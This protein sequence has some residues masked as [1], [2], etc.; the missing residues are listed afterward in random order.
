VVP[1]ETGTVPTKLTTI[2]VVT[3]EDIGVVEEVN[4]VSQ[5]TTVVST[6]KPT[7]E[8]IKKSLKQPNKTSTAKPP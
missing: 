8:P 5:E 3:K 2:K 4:E 1:G 7:A 6:A